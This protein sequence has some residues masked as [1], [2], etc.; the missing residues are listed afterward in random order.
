MKCPTCGHPLATS[1]DE[2]IPPRNTQR[3]KYAFDALTVGDSIILPMTQVR[4][5]SR[6]QNW[7]SAKTHPERWQRE[8]T[9]RKI[10]PTETQLWRTK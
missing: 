4:T 7:R 2:P 1:T 6:I 8:F 9:T 3:R 10:S 5:W